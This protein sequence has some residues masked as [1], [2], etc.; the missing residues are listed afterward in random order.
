MSGEQRQGSTEGVR[1][2][3]MGGE[4]EVDLT[5]LS[6]QSVVRTACIENDWD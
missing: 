5:S 4:V 6:P 2:C 1:E 3:E